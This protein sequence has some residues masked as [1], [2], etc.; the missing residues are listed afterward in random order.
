MPLSQISLKTPF[1]APVAFGRRAVPQ[2]FEELQQPEEE[3]RQRALNSL[4]DLMH[5]PERIYQTVNGGFLEQLKVLLK[6][7]DSTV[8]KK[9]CK[10]LHILTAHSIGRYRQTGGRQTGDRQTGDRQEAD[11]QETVDRQE[12]GRQETVDRQ[13]VDRRQAD[14]QEDDRQT[15]R[16]TDRQTDRQQIDH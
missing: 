1:R 12:T 15:G 8:R 10:L 2:L 7:D 3:R 9:T 11:R 6:D 13:T 14:R 16:Q 4:C 5:D